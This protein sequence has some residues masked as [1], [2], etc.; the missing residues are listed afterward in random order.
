MIHVM[1]VEGD[2]KNGAYPVMFNHHSFGNV[3]LQ[4]G[5]LNG[6]KERSVDMDSS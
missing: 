5:E 3:P 4:I 2:H 1:M 6:N